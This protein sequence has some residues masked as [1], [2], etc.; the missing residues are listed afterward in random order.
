MFIT[1][2]KRVLHLR[3]ALFTAHGN[4]TERHVIEISIRDG[5]FCGWGEASPLPG[6][7]VESFQEAETA[8]CLLYTSAAADE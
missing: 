4:T 7:G 2:H 5:Q 3:S 1:L 6:F 8:L